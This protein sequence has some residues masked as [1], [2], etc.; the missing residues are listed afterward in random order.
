MCIRD[1]VIISAK[2]AG[3]AIVARLFG[4]TKPTLLQLGWFARAYKRWSAWKNALLAQVRA[5]W[6]WRLGRV[7][8]H[9]LKQRW[10]RLREKLYPR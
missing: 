1:R 2:I 7:L 9:R 6:P 3:T 4:L 5:S 8:K 10:Q